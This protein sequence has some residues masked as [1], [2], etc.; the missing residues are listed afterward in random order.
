MKTRDTQIFGFNDFKEILKFEYLN[1]SSA[2][3]TYSMRAFSRD[4]GLKP[5]SFNDIVNGRY[6]I[7]RRTAQNLARKL[8]YDQ[9]ETE[10]F[11]DLVESL[12]GRSDL[13]R[14]TAY[15]R[16]SKHSKKPLFEKVGKTK[17]SEIFSRWYHLATLELVSL[18]GSK[19]NWALCAEALGISE[20]EAKASIKLLLELGALHFDGE[21]WTRNLKYVSVD[22]PA[23]PGLIRGFH[24]QMMKKALDSVDSQNTLQRSLLS[25][26]LSIK[27]DRLPQAFE[28]L[29]KLHDQFA[30]ENEESKAPDA[31]YGLSFQFFR[32]DQPGKTT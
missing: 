6:G 12:H 31:V 5:S 9:D 23:P 22:E 1:R 27:S 15:I 30:G 10:Y 21:T 20:S 18:H 3:K 19:F 11:A 24:T 25:S 32:L 4:L 13:I 2:R 16:L 29:E 26:V 8:G 17:S 7:S 28:Q 14:Q